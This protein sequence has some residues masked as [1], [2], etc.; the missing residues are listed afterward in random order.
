M[1]KNLV[2]MP[3]ADVAYTVY[4]EGQFYP[5]PLS[6]TNPT[7]HLSENHSREVLR[8][9]CREYEA[10]RRNDTGVKFHDALAEKDLKSKFS[11]RAETAQGEGPAS[12]WVMHG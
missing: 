7:N 2:V 5:E 9:A 11:T 8:M 6:N 1:F 12:K 4:V 3:P 10:G